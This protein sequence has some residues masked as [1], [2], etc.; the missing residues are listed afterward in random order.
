MLHKNYIFQVLAL[1][2][3]L[4]VLFVPTKAE[5]MNEQ[6]PALS[7]YPV[8]NE[9]Q[10]FID[11]EDYFS[12][13]ADFVLAEQ[14]YHEVYRQLPSE[15]VAERAYVGLRRVF[16]L[17]NGRKQNEAL[18]FMDEIEKILGEENDE[19]Q[20]LWA[21]LYTYR[22]KAYAVNQKT[23]KALEFNDKAMVIKK[24]NYPEAHIKLG[25]SYAVYTYVHNYFTRR[26]D[27]VASYLDLEEKVVANNP[28]TY[29]KYA[30]V[31]L[32]YNLAYFYS[33][34]GEYLKASTNGKKA[35]Q[36]LDKFKE[37]H[38]TYMS[39]LYTLMGAVYLKMEDGSPAI[40]YITKSLEYPVINRQDSLDRAITYTNLAYG[41][42][43]GV[44]QKLATTY[45]KKALTYYGPE[46]L[47][48][49]AYSLDKIAEHYL[50]YPDIE[51]QQNILDSA[52]YYVD[53]NI[54]FHKRIYPEKSPFLAAPYMAL[55]HLHGINENYDQVLSHIQTA[56]INSVPN[57]NNN[58]IDSNPSVKDCL[59]GHLTENVLMKK[60]YAL[61]NVAKLQN[62]NKALLQSISI[63]H[64][65]DSIYSFKKQYFN[66]ESS[67]IDNPNIQTN[68]GTIIEILHHIY[69]KTQD[70]KYIQQIFNYM[71]RVKGNILLRN[72]SSIK[73]S[74]LFGVPDSLLIRGKAISTAIN[75]YLRIHP[76]RIV[77]N[78]KEILV[79]NDSLYQLLQQ[80]A[81]LENIFKEFYPQYYQVRFQS[82]STNLEDVKKRLNDHALIEFYWARNDL[83]A[84][85]IDNKTSNIF[86][87]PMD[88]KL[89]YNIDSH[90]NFL[91][92]NSKDG[93]LNF[94][95]NAHELYVKLL[96][97][98]LKE[99]TPSKLIIVTDGPL[100]AIPFETL[101]T[102]ETQ[103]ESINYRDL[104]YLIKNTA[105]SYA[106]STNTLFQ[107]YERS[108]ML[109]NPRL[110]AFSFSDQNNS[111]TG[112]EVLNQ[113]NLF[114]LAGA[115][116][117]V[118]SLGKVI[119][120]SRFKSLFGNAATKS[121]FFE[122]HQDFDLI[123]LALHAQSDNK[124]RFNNR[125]FFHPKKDNLDSES[126]I[127]FAHE[128]YDLA[129]PPRL[130]VLGAC[131]TGAG[132]N[133]AG[134]GTYSTARGFIY[135]GTPSVVMSLWP[136]SDQASKYINGS[137]YDQILHGT[138]LD[139]ALRKA[140]LSFIQSA[141]EWTAH[142]SR[143]A[144][145]N[146]IG[147]TKPIVKSNWS[148][149]YWLS[150]AII[151][152][153]LVFIFNRLRKRNN[154]IRD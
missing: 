151:I 15:M 37:L 47:K 97:P 1:L 12:N 28:N 149:W 33:Y 11:A 131:N 96:A 41:Y 146:V 114:P 119:P 80:K 107:A 113:Y 21:D 40:K 105:I 143:W 48:Y 99:K 83:F 81:E 55:A 46:D 72:L 123:H 49:K 92:Q 53:K 125:I 139:E 88:S 30:Q 90:I 19:N 121:A 126:F 82:L 14:L 132:T 109:E 91:K 95:K 66:D 65:L 32:H 17:S 62:D 104:P 144:A 86:K 24:A 57:F 103:L 67:I 140:K 120:P 75:N 63:N 50:S 4:S 18:E 69:V 150:S 152:S 22:A 10:N 42:S 89:R 8:L 39:R 31:A 74:E 64:L 34:Q 44:D 58:S 84:L 59:Y 51:S 60:G 130:V 147:S 136:L 23:D 70:E 35:I 68:Y 106:Y 127:C 26:L 38:L 27:L 141:D 110:L 9:K 122:N 16:A 142:P 108:S 137:F 20:L 3:F 118:A 85:Y 2:L 94:Q 77:S 5:A 45:F 134:E 145:L 73:K 78:T 133:Y 7:P 124:N 29:S 128:L 100:A 135:A 111:N 36:L 101:L 87:I 116:K 79:S 93:F 25:E 61:F 154:L 56:L 153:F 43:M 112:S 52:Y 6:T 13:K 76:E 54:K 71:E 98:I 115:A 129:P 138:P 102:H 148:Y 117:E